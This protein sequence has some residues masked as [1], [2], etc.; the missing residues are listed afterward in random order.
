MSS[1]ALYFLYPL[2]V[3][4]LVAGGPPRWGEIL[5]PDES[6][7]VWKVPGAE[8]EGTR[9]DLCPIGRQTAVVRS[10][11]YGGLAKS[12]EIYEISLGGVDASTSARSGEVSHPQCLRRN[13]PLNDC[14]CAVPT[15]HLG[16]PKKCV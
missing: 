12:E 14:M 10:G 16:V 3:A 7:C 4:G 5:F 13:C 1:S 11:S 2:C 8:G 6:G 9:F 15:R